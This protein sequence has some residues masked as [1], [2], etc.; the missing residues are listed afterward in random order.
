MILLMLSFIS[1]SLE[2]SGDLFI[3]F[4]SGSD[5]LF[6]SDVS[7][8]VRVNVLRI[9][10]STRFFIQ[11]STYLEMAEQKGKVTFDPAFAN[12]S[13][14]F[15]FQYYRG[16]Y[17]SLYIDHYCRHQIDRELEEGKAVFN[18]GNFVL[19]NVSDPAHRFNKKNYFRGAYLFYPQGIFVDYLNSKHYY[20]HR[21]I[22]DFGRNIN[23][24]TQLTIKTEY[25][26]SNH[27]SR[28]K[29][30]QIRPGIF[31]FKQVDNR[32]LYGFLHYYLT[33]KVPLRSPNRLLFLGFGFSF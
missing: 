13:I 32:T 24:F 4:Y 9:R 12:Y 10:N 27:T 1:L 2:N 16:L 8:W 15:G 6:N 18:A 29:Y 22:L 19:S 30:Y 14:I 7:M 23:S 25:T 3:G 20:R 21:F 31:L 11:Y 26:L 28:R 5:S 33:A 17:F